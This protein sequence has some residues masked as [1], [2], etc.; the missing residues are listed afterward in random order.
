MTSDSLSASPSRSSASP[1][2]YALVMTSWYW[3]S[4]VV[5]R[6]VATASLK[7]NT[8]AKR[9][10]RPGQRPS[11]AAMSPSVEDL[12]LGCTHMH[13]LDPLIE[14]GLTRNSCPAL[15]WTISG[16]WG[17]PGER[18]SRNR[19]LEVAQVTQ[20]ALRLTPHLSEHWL[21]RM[22]RTRARRTREGGRKVGRVVSSPARSDGALARKSRC[23]SQ[24][25]IIN[26]SASPLSSVCGLVCTLCWCVCADG[27]R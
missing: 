10:I 12:S 9:Q 11:S 3:C 26:I 14:S 18:N 25:L 7:L 5:R 22:G 16:F 1:S 20:A 6:T 23:N 24:L 15:S 13:S 27:G 21:G 8:H 17:S 2:S 19:T 4:A